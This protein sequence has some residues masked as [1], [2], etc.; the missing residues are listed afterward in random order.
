MPLRAKRVS[1]N[2]KTYF[3]QKSDEGPFLRVADIMLRY[4]HSYTHPF[5]DLIRLG[6]RSRWSHS[7]LI[8]LEPKPDQETSAICLVDVTTRKGAFVE[9]WTEEMVAPPN[10]FSDG[11][12]GLRLDW[13][14]EAADEQAKHTSDDPERVHG[15]DYLRKVRDVA[16]SQLHTVYDHKTVWELTALYI[17]QAAH[18][19]L[20][21]IPQIADLAATAE[22]LLEKW[23]EAD[24]SDQPE[25]NFI[26]SGL[27]Q[28]SFFEALRQS[29]LRNLS[30]LENRPAA[31]SNLR[32]MQSVMFRDDP[33]QVISHYIQSV[34]ANEHIL[35]DPIPESVMN[36]LRTATPAD[37]NNS[38]KLAWRYIIHKGSVWYMYEAPEGGEHEPGSKDEAEVLK[39][40]EPDTGLL[41][42]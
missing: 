34:Q 42:S 18:R 14:V 37:F 39:L 26:C 36:L 10:K 35:A 13:Y 15:I 41:S 22:G 17:E 4:R 21:A 40:T 31:L 20:K 6:T 33:D 24:S 23:D 3:E 29:I 9:S 16:L 32:N 19:H 28:Y 27:V 7:S 25:L 30:I 1:D 11:I 2:P 12:K 8:Y 38:P 5:T